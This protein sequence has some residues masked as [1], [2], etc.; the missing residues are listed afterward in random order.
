MKPYCLEIPELTYDPAKLL[1]VADRLKPHWRMFRHTSQDVEEQAGAGNRDGTRPGYFEIPSPPVREGL[2]SQDPVY[3][4]LRDLRDQIDIELSGAKFMRT[5][6]E[7]RV[8]P[9]V[10][11]GRKTVFMFP[12][13]PRDGF[14]PVEWYGDNR[15]ILYT[16]FYKI[17]HA[18]VLN[19]K[20]SHG[21]MNSQREFRVAFQFTSNLSLDEI[22]DRYTSGTLLKNQKNYCGT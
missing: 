10:D 15:E 5:L 8:S 16:H 22:H 20:I 7:M 18:T 17:G 1:A 11:W 14:A 19:G 2:A 12:L 21:V 13:I 3:D 6:P 9:H 4:H